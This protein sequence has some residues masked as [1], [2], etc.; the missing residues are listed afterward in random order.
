MDNPNV[1][2]FPAN[3]AEFLTML[4]IQHQDLNGLSPE[5]LADRYLNARTAIKE[6]LN[7]ETERQYQQM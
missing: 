1:N 4:Y 2:V 6:R 5:E 7:Q 3:E